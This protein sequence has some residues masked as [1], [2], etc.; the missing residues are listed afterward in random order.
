MSIYLKI[1]I[2]SLAEE[3][4]I[5]RKE[6]RKVLSYART[7]DIPAPKEIHYRTYESLHR[8]R[9]YDVRTEAR[10]THL[11]YAFLRGVPYAS[12]EAKRSDSKKASYAE[13]L[14]WKR[15]SD[16]VKKYGT[17]AQFAEFVSGKWETACS[18]TEVAMAS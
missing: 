17:T 1:K 14:T 9:T 16:M 12:V 13:T 3:A 5:I 10:A 2:K 15:A 18:S 7:T 8:H 6:E 4:R 11:A